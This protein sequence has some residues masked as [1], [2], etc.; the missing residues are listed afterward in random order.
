MPKKQRGVFEHPKGSGVYWINY[1]DATGQ[2]HRESIGS[3][4]LACDTYYERKHAIREGR[5]RPPTRVTGI[6]FKAL[7]EAAIVGRR[8]NLEP[9]T[10]EEYHYMSRRLLKWFGTMS[11]AKITAAM[12]TE[13]LGEGLD[14]GW[15]GTTAN[16]YHALLSG[17]F[18]WGVENQKIEHNPAR[19]VK[20]FREPDMRVR[21]LDA[22]EE[23]SLRRVIRKD[24]SDR[25]AELDLAL[26]TGARRIEL[27]TLRWDQVDLERG[28]LTIIG[29]AHSNSRRSRIRHVPINAMAARALHEL[30]EQSEGSEFVLPRRSNMGFARGKRDRRR[31]FENSIEKAGIVN[32]RFHDLRH[33]FASRLRMAG[34]ALEDIMEFLGHTTIAMVLRYAHLAPA[35]QKANIDK[36]VTHYAGRKTGPVLLERKR[37]NGENAQEQS[38]NS[39]AIKKA[40]LPEQPLTSLVKSH[41]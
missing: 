27:H 1:Y 20:R 3:F 21:F 30:H 9:R 16:R 8:H 25:E 37:K 18:R 36:L 34:V 12:I 38:R 33:T 14:K 2:R 39:T 28:Q 41:G 32:F 15:S 31:W 11:A 7:L 26:H 19:D 35:H 13:R 29:K 23:A 22:D 5:F 17:I 40:T 6:T 4:S 10:Q 24:F